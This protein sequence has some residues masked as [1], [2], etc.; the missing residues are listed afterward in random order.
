MARPVKKRW[1]TIDDSSLTIEFASLAYR[2]AFIVQNSPCY[3]DADLDHLLIPILHKDLERMMFK[4]RE[5]WVH[6]DRFNHNV[7]QWTIYVGPPD[8]MC[9]ESTHFLCQCACGRPLSE[10]RPGQ[11]I[12]PKIAV[13]PSVPGPSGPNTGAAN[14]L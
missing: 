6:C 11:F 3:N 2:C 14:T 9:V 12:H 8:H 7:S 13:D 5:F 4:N 1:W 10:H